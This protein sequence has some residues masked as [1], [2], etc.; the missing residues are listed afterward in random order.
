MSKL[1]YEK[2]TKIVSMGGVEQVSPPFQVM[3]KWVDGMEC[4]KVPSQSSSDTNYHVLITKSGVDNVDDEYICGCPSF[5][6][7]ILHTP[8]TCKHCEAVKIVKNVGYSNDLKKQIEI[9]DE[10]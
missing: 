3:D 6:Y 9:E 5:E 2:I 7:D 4:Y 10:Y 8:P 1:N